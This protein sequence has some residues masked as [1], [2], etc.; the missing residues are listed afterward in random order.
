MSAYRTDP[1][2]AATDVRFC[3]DRLLVLSGEDGK[4][5]TIGDIRGDLEKEAAR[6]GAS[7]KDQGQRIG[8]LENRL[9]YLE[10]IA[11]VAVALAAIALV[12]IGAM[13]KALF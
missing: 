9:R 5:G 13:L 11:A 12:A 6:S 1:T 10:K 3:R 7:A 2:A 4:G 8:E